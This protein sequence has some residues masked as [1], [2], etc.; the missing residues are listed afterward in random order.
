M[1]S[2]N[3]I[4]AIDQGTTNTKVILVN[5]VGDV[6]AQA[7][8]PVDIEFPQPAWVQQS[9]SQIW[10]SVQRAIN[11]CL[12]A[13]NHPTPV[14]IAITNQREAGVAWD[15]N[16]GQPI[17]PL[18]S[19]QCRR[20][21]PY[22]D[23]LRKRDVEDDLLSRTGLIID[24]LFSASKF[25]WL[26][27]NAPDGQKRAANGDICVGT[28]DS[29][30]LWNLTGGRRHRTDVSNASRTQLFNLAEQAWDPYLVNDIFEIPA[31]CLPEVL[32]SSAVFGESVQLD[33][34]PSGIP[35][36]SMIGDS[37]AALFGHAGFN[38]GVVKAPM[39]RAVH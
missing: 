25:R 38:P 2:E 33:D 9:P 10:D 1:K 31:V 4:L 34:L 13:A 37:H 16:T 24:P 15:R 26:L 17:G 23:Q 8:T 29:W 27:D 18:I 7:S 28:V 3:L 21:A 14:A 39:A 30:L 19:W 12:R 22:C 20:T 11:A 5:H 32:N 35:I 36:A 6:V